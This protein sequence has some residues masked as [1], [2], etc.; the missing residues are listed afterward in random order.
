MKNDMRRFIILAITLAG[1]AAGSACGHTPVNPKTTLTTQTQQARVPGEY[2][3]TVAARDKVQAIS[4]LYGQFGI[5]GIRDLGSN[6]FLVTLSADPGPARMEQLRGD[7][8]D[9]KAVQPNFV[10]GTRGIGKAQ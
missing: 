6:I 3:V 9:I 7:N 1:A 8:A 5:K 4:D 2:L 10:Y